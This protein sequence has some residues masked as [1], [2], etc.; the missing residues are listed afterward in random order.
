MSS[1]ICCKK[2]CVQPFSCAKIHT[3]RLQFFHEGRQYF[4]SHHLLNVHRQIYHDSDRKEMIT[5]ESCDVCPNAWYT[6]MG[7]SRV[8]YYRWKVN[9]KSGVRTDEHGNVGMT[10]PRIHT[11]QAMATL[12]QMLEQS[13]DHMSHKTSTLETREKVVSKCLPSSWHW[14]DS[15]LELNIVNAQLGLNKVST[16]GLN[17]I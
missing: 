15:L 6:I 11:L 5:L 12:R 17:R 7:V 10:K 13:I 1:I 16:S 2:N 14:K 9:A 4:K 3:L 8:T